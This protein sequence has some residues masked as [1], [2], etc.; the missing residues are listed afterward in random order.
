ML[1]HPQLPTAV[2][3]GQWLEAAGLPLRKQV[4]YRPIAHRRAPCGP[5]TP[6]LCMYPQSWCLCCWYN[7]DEPHGPAHNEN[8]PP[9]QVWC[10]SA[11]VAEDN[12]KCPASRKPM[13][14]G[15]SPAQ[16]SAGT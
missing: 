10:H 2:G 12:V 13:R 5:C 8:A 9:K 1:G 7:V 3:V 16:E 14:N 15:W 6:A 4:V 11:Q